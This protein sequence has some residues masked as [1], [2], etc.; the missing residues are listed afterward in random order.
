MSLSR[1][2]LGNTGLE[3]VVESLRNVLQ[4][5]HST[6]AGGVSSLRL[7]T[8]VERSSLSGWVTTGR[9][10]LLLTMERTTT[11]SVTQSVRFVVTLTE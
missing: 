2:S 11:T 4:V 7:S 5:L 10:S 8:P 3:T 1:S 6:S 9:T